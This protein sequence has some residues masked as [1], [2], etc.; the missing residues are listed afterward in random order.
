MNN[1]IG[2]RLRWLILREGREKS[3]FEVFFE[4]EDVA[5]LAVGEAYLCERENF[6][7]AIFDQ[8][9]RLPIPI[10]PEGDPFH[11][12]PYLRPELAPRL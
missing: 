1:E 7:R 12:P 11:L 9:G 5:L 8:P 4:K 10:E 6:V 3:L 2:L